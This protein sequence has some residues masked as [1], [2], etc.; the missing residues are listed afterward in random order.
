MIDETATGVATA[1]ATQQVV[2]SLTSGISLKFLWG[3]INFL[4]VFEFLF[5]IQANYPPNFQEIAT[6]A[7]AANF[8]IPDL[9]GIPNFISVWVKEN[10]I[11]S[12]SLNEIFKDE[13]FEGT[14]FT[15]LYRQG[16]NIAFIILL[17]FLPLLLLKY[18]FLCVYKNSGKCRCKYCIGKIDATYSF[19][20]FFRFF[21]ELYLEMAVCVFISITKL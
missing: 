9:E 17:L 16:T 1:V 18:F 8:N 5:L 4:Q 10:D 12:D 14:A 6:I 20:G 21:L 11:S 13:E 7:E 19:N 15:D 3:I 2:V